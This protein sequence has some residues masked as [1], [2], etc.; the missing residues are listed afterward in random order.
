VKHACGEKAE[1]KVLATKHLNTPD[2]RKSSTNNRC[3]SPEGQNLRQ[4]SFAAGN[5]QNTK[6]VLTQGCIF[7]G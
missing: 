1:N 6:A 7:S 3:L 4:S 2:S 5:P